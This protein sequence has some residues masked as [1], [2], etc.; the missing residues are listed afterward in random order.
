MTDQPPD[1]PL[2]EAPDSPFTPVPVIR[3]R[4]D[5][6]SPE[7]QRRFIA[8]LAHT[9]C[10]S[11]AARAVGST[12]TSAYRLR[13]RPDAEGFAAAWDAALSDAR[14]RRFDALFERAT[15][16]VL[17]PRRYRNEYVG[18]RHFYDNAAGLAALREPSTPPAPRAK[19]TKVTKVDECTAF[20]SPFTPRDAAAPSTIPVRRPR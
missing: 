15:V 9:A 6:W 7:R 3:A 17:V 13:A 11:A 14:A 4:H 20:A 2:D 5:G 16:G 8:A 12:R 10:V 19:V 18:S 1:P